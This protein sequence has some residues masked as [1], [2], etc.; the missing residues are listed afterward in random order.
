MTKE[1]K[2]YWIDRWNKLKPSPQIDMTIKM[3]GG[4]IKN[5]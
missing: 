4:K 3:W 5:K 1:E 2:Q